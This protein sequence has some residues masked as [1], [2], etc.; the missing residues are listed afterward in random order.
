MV[1]GV[2]F[3]ALSLMLMQLLYNQGQLVR[4]RVQL[5]NAADATAYSVAKLGAR[6]N[7]YSA[8]SNRSAVAAIDIEPH[9]R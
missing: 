8:Y 2:I 9:W 6:R 5:E 4:H 1:L 3:L 7:N